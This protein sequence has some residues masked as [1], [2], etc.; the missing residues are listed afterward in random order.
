MHTYF[1]M[2]NKLILEKSISKSSMFVQNIN[3]IT[4]VN[5]MSMHYKEGR[6]VMENST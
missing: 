2:M 5:I 6:L 1:E 3:L 4:C